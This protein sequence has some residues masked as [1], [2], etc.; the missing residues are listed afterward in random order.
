METEEIA[1]LAEAERKKNRQ[2][3]KEKQTQK[4]FNP[5]DWMD[6]VETRKWMRNNL[7]LPDSFY[8]FL[9]VLLLAAGLLSWFYLEDEKKWA[10]YGMIIAWLS[11]A[12]AAVTGF[13]IGLFR[14]KSGKT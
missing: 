12:L 2:S 8:S 4:P 10:L 3:E 9:L 14:K 6:F 7:A 5:L 13:F 11:F 1:K